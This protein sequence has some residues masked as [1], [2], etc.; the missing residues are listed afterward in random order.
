VTPA[1]GTFTT[2]TGS[3][4]ASLNGLTVGR[5]AGAVS[6]NTAVGASALSTNSTG[7]NG[8]AIGY[9]AL[10]TSNSDRNTAVGY[11]AATSTTGE[12]N[13][14]FGAFALF[15]NGTGTQ[16]SSFG[17]VSLYSNTSGNYNC[18]F[19]LGTLGNNTT[20]ASNAAHGSQALY[21]NTTAS[22]NTAVGY[23]AGYSNTTGTG[24][25]ALG[26]QAGYN[27]TTANRNTLVGIITGFGLTTG[28][29]NTFIG[30]P[31]STD[32]VGCGYLITTG[33][34][35][36]IIG[37]YT[38]NND[39]LDIRT[40]SNYVVLSTGIGNRQLTMGESLTVALDSAVPVSGTG[41][42]FPASQSAS[43]DANT[44]DDYEEGTWTPTFFGT[45]VAG[46]PTYNT[47]VAAYTKIGR[48]VSVTCLIYIT[49]L[50]GMTGNI[51][52]GGLPFTA[53]TGGSYYGGFAIAEFEG[54]TFS[55]GRTMLGLE[56]THGTT[57]IVIYNNGS[58]VSASQQTIANTANST[59]IVFSGTYFSA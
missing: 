42:T 39:G 32:A 54:F 28:S 14:V 2:V 58:G 52:I 59:I 34:N 12:R 27:H 41:I 19:G 9:Q 16:N 10:K 25:T 48:S 57:N 40:S 18:A 36:T 20:G 17:D 13:S 15:T 38:G 56:P 51:Q 33:S 8:T 23:Q 44:L 6:T 49:N 53:M 35:N 24:H 43:S 37:G 45:T 30:T 1:A 46:S 50:G 22:N 7:A 55:S 31:G 21:S 29:G 47:R 11:L 4:D 5:G 3:N 26:Y